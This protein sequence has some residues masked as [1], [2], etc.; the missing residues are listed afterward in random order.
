[1]NDMSPQRL[2]R[3]SSLQCKVAQRFSERPELLDAADH[4]LVA[5]WPHYLPNDT[6]D[7]RVLYLA[8]RH[9][10]T[11]SLWV[12]PLSRVLAERYCLRRTLNLTV[13]EDALTTRVDGDPAWQVYIPLH[14]V[15]LLI[16][17]TAPLL[18][19]VYQQSLATYW[20]RFDSSGETPWHRYAEDLR[21]RFR[22]AIET[23]QNAGSLTAFALVVARMVYAYPDP[24]QRNWQN[25]AGLSVSQLAVDFSQD[26]TLDNELASALLIEHRDAD[27]QRNLVLLYTL[28][29]KLL[30][31][32][33][34]QDLLASIARYWPPLSRASSREVSIGPPAQ[35][36]FESMALGLLDQQLRV[37]EH[38]AKAYRDKLGALNMSLELDR[39][40]SMLDLCSNAESTQ[41]MALSA[42]LPD[43]LRNAKSQPLLRYSTL[44]LDVARA[45]KNTDGQFWLDG[46]DNAED[47]ANRQLA[48]RFTADHPGDTLEPGQIRIVN[49]QTIAAAAAR[50]GLGSTGEVNP[51]T[52]SLAQLAIANVGLLKPGRV[53]LH[54]ESAEPLPDWL[55]EDYL[56]TVVG[57]LDI[58]SAYPAMLRS[59]LLDDTSQREQ[60]QR[61]LIAQLAS[62]LPAL[63]QE[64][65]LRGKLPDQDIA[66]R[67]AQVFCATDDDD[68]KHW[69]IRPLGLLKA[70]GSTV[71]YPCNT[72]LIEPRSPNADSCLLYRP[73]HEDSLL[74]FSDRLAL[75]V[76]IST[77]GA[78]QDDLLQRLP[79][80]D[81]RFYA[82]GGFLEPHL[83]V[84]LDD[85]SAIPFGK[86]APVE[87]T[88]ESPSNDLGADLYLACVNESVQ[89]FEEHASTS[90]QTRWARWKE[91]G[92]LLFN[93]LLPLAGGTLGK[94]AWLAQMEVTLAEF[95]STDAE[96]DPTGHELAGVNLLVNIALLLAVHSSN[97]LNEERGT[98]RA[99]DAPAMPLIASDPQPVSPSV[100][101]DHPLV[102]LD[103]SWARPAQT[104]TTAQSTALRALRADIDVAS[105]GEPLPNGI[106]R[107]LY[108][109][110]EK[111]YTQLHVN[112]YQVMLDM[113][114]NQ[115]RIVGPDETAGPWLR[116]DETGRWQLD[117][118]LTLKGG[119]PLSAQI[120]KLQLE[121]ESALRTANAV[122]KT[123]R[124]T[125]DAKI[126]EQATLEKLVATS[127][128]DAR[129]QTC[130]DKLD[131]LS[132]FWTAHIEHLKQRNILQPVKEF[133]KVHAFALYQDSFCQR[134]LRKVLHLRYQPDRDQI[135]QAARLQ[136]SGETLTPADAGIIAARLD[137]LAPLIDRMIDNNR[138]LRHCQ[139]EL[140]KLASPQQPEIQQWRD[141]AYT[142]RASPE[143]E[144]I[145]RFL[146]LEG[147]LNRM[148][149]VHGLSEEACR[150]RDRF[151]DS[152]ELGIAQRARLFKLQ[153]ADDEITARL[154]RSII[155]HLETAARQLQIFTTLI[156][157]DSPLQTVRQMNEQLDWLLERNRKDLSELPDYPPISTLGQL[158]K[159]VPGLIETT[160]HGLL[161]ADPRSDDANTV[162]IPGPD[163]K[164]PARTYHL[165]QGDW[166]ELRPSRAPALATQMS[167]KRLLKDSDRLIAQAH[168]EVSSLQAHPNR[169]LPVE[170]EESVLH[171]R[172]RLLERV[173][174]IEARLTEDNETD[175]AR[176]GKDA[177]LVAGSL[178]RLAQEL[179]ETATRLR[180]SAAL[181]QKPR[182]GEVMYLVDGGHVQVRA[183]GARSRLAR[184]KGRPADFLDEYSIRHEGKVL[185]YAHFHYPSMTTAKA[186]FTAGHLKT[187]EQRHMPGQRYSDGSGR[188]FDVYRAPIT[189]TAAARY[190]FGL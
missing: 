100:V 127:L 1:M 118:S 148:T 31:F 117:L 47:F 38:R 88:V 74:Q 145:L 6:H 168:D 54:T 44:L 79:A 111:L 43:W 167:L 112:V 30:A 26:G 22:E 96:R 173:D 169:Y 50:P 125:I 40:T 128:D 171:Q 87:L 188:V 2:T 185:W 46:V 56:R 20:S 99:L 67:I 155:G 176:A 161:L 187:A 14:Q 95:A 152:F 12:R 102:H 10:R 49:Y 51:V 164:T 48:A 142:M 19:E 18:L 116:R 182:M 140:N 80:E 4:I 76:A 55:N 25:A 17:D 5:Q 28:T 90:A 129:L 62:Q 39:L 60:R 68:P 107:G 149:L 32:A 83:F 72:W 126:K 175:E 61:L 59:K 190:F 150:W 177:E 143:Q 162:D 75:F 133:K 81:R 158:R 136:Q 114:R 183:E 35:G 163:D 179:P 184:V 134:L 94:V 113:P 33:S 141:L 23:H 151:W 85:T 78:L 7:P 69:I 84:P 108:L 45:C 104:L 122:I 123:D 82:H 172:T 9:P 170:I 130:Q 115:M 147:L 109:H 159:K 41:R 131:T 166:V 110:G 154:L 8:S 165:K 27:P 63:A 124:D 181:T 52:F 77:P 105:L 160:E 91:L 11:G 132:G 139:D 97:R 103:F 98:A 42:Q 121:K 15:E 24:A 135:L 16:N 57:E 189:S 186:D 157:G 138:R 180:V 120:R 71:D 137:R 64:L 36:D 153:N 73:L 58:A 106:L 156:R 144:L 29:G 93:T 34:R 21:N 174:A 66:S 13:G 146:R 89:T 178:R 119:M 101:Q 86:P 65:Y 92:W 53:E 70:P 37:I 3:S